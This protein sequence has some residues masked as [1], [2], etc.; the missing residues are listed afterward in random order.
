MKLIVSIL[1]KYYKYFIEAS[2]GEMIFQY[3]SI[4]K[5]EPSRKWISVFWDR[6]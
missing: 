4:L 6:V 5:I 3:D 1:G 2:L